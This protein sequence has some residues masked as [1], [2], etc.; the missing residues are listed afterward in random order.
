MLAATKISKTEA[1][2]RELVLHQTLENL[3]LEAELTRTSIQLQKETLEQ[4]RQVTKIL[5]PSQ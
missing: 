2:L 5:P 1:S 4:Y 3:K